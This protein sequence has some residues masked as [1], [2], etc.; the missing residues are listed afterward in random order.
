MK[1]NSALS[2]ILILGSAGMT[3]CLSTTRAVQ[4]TQA[5]DVYRT[6]DVQQLEKEVSDRDAAIQTLSSSVEVTASTGGGKEGEVKT[7]TSFRGYIIVQKPRNLRV[8]LQL[9]VIGSR[10]MDM[11]SDGRMF[12][13]LIP[14]RN[15]AIVGANEVTKPSKNG[16]ENLRPAVF[17]D[18]L[19]VPGVGPDEYVSLTEST[20]VLQPESRHKP[21][22]EEPDYDLAVMRVKSGH[23]L[24]HERTIH[25]SRVD[26]L[27][28]EQDIYDDQERI[29]TQATYD[30]Y[31]DFNGTQFPTLINISRPLDELALKIEVTKLQVN[32]ELPEDQFELQLPTGITVQKME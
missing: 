13:I 32:K 25:F 10:A 4:K 1:N 20:R 5:P 22:I 18:S 14:P 17:L 23:L 21:A 3:G 6:A 16:L 28:F 19:L 2:V 26:M 31:Q 11:V 8:I 29:V 12:K 7:Y 27:P 24:V 15:K 30:K 9:P